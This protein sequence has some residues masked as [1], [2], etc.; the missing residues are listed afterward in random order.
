MLINYVKENISTPRVFCT[1]SIWNP[2]DS[3]DFEPQR[4]G[5]PLLDGQKPARPLKIPADPNA[6][7]ASVPHPFA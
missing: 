5:A 6:V 3:H 7:Q 1:R 4:C 2:W